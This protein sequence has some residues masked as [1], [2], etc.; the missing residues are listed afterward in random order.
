MSCRPSIRL[1]CLAA[2]VAS[3]LAAQTPSVPAERKEILSTAS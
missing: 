1:L 2:C 3:G